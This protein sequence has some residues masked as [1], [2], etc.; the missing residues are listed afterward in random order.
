MDS[1]WVSGAQ[2]AGSIPARATSK[3]DSARVGFFVC[4]TI[5]QARGLLHKVLPETLFFLSTVYHICKTCIA[6]RPYNLG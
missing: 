3:A 6:I 1:T 4:N 5:E 2:D